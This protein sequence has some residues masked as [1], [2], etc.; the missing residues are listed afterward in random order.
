MNRKWDRWQMAG[1]SVHFKSALT[2]P[3]IH[4]LLQTGDIIMRENVSHSKDILSL[5]SNMIVVDI[6][7]NMPRLILW[8]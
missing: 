2:N 8:L 5:D 6:L 1:S 3:R 4:D 7:P